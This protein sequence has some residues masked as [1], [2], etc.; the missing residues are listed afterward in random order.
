[1]ATG[2]ILCRGSKLRIMNKKQNEE[3]NVHQPPADNF[4]DG[5][6]LSWSGGPGLS[7][8]VVGSGWGC[9]GW[10]VGGS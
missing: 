3:K 7:G 4:R 8:W 10:V 1:M 2:K 6:F 9:G 5:D